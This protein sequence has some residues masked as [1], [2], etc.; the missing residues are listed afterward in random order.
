MLYFTGTRKIE[1]RY[2]YVEIAVVIYFR[3]PIQVCQQV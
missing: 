3:L 2:F 1:S